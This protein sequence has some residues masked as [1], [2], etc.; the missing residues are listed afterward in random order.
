[1][2]QRKVDDSSEG[3][4]S[5]RPLF[6]PPQLGEFAALLGSTPDAIKAPFGRAELA[7]DLLYPDGP[8]PRQQ[9]PDNGMRSMSWPPMLNPCWI[10]SEGQIRESGT[11]YRLSTG[12]RAR[13]ATLTRRTR[14]QPSK[15]CC[16][17]SPASTA[18]VEI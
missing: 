7:L 5:L 14:W 18:S 4:S 17:T 16:E 1:V 6:G 2:P 15:Q 12:G 10:D 3:Y 8:S 13:K 11:G 9:M